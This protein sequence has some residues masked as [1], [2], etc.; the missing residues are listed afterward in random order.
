M[1]KQK[2]KEPEPCREHYW[3]KESFEN[4]PKCGWSGTEFENENNE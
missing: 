2:P 4:C 3:D 1:N